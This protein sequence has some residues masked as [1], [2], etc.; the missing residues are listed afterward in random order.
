MTEQSSQL[1]QYRSA[2]TDL[3]QRLARAGLSEEGI[4]QALGVPVYALYEWI[5]TKPEFAA[6]VEQGWVEFRLRP[7]RSPSR[8]K[9]PAYTWALQFAARNKRPHMAAALRAKMAEM[10]AIGPEAMARF[11]DELRARA[12][13]IQPLRYIPERV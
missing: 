1:V 5:E 13:K 6:A 11:N 8:Y 9:Y 7:P 12:L 10:K 4:A 2:Y 3:A